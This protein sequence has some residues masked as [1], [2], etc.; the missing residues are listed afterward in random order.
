MSAVS[1]LPVHRPSKE[2]C[3][4][5]RKGLDSVVHSLDPGVPAARHG[6]PQPSSEKIALTS[7]RCPWELPKAHIPSGQ[8]GILTLSKRKEGSFL[9]AHLVAQ[10]ILSI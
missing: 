2:D 6:V 8:R 10:T 5:P 4:P 7:S 1:T 3:K 9:N